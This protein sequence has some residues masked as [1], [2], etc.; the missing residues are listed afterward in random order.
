MEGLGPSAAPDSTL[1]S[2]P[3]SR[4][5]LEA[6]GSRADPPQTRGRTRATPRRSRLPSN[7]EAREASTRLLASF[8]KLRAGSVLEGGA[9]V[10]KR[11]ASARRALTQAGPPPA[12]PAAR[13]G[14]WERGRSPVEGPSRLPSSPDVLRQHHRL[15]VRVRQTT[16]DGA[17]TSGA[18]RC[19][20][21]QN[22]CDETRFYSRWQP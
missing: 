21:A 12:I 20:N 7:E 16:S 1:A 18:A 8:Q 5:Q 22:Q 15:L 11:T 9:S 10:D 2:S 17:V 3:R 6:H 14:A 4:I 19:V 13:R